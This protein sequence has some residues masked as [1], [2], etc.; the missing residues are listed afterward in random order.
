MPGFLRIL[1]LPFSWIW[2]LALRIRHG[3]YDLGIFASEEAALPC[4]VVGNL[5]L[6]GTGKTPHTLWLAHHYSGKRRIAVLSRGYGRKT[7]GFI[8]VQAGMSAADCGDEALEYLQELDGKAIIAVCEDRPFGIRRLKELHPALELVILDDALQ[9]RALR[10]GY[11]ILLS[12][13]ESPWYKDHLIPAG[14]L[15]DLKIRSGSCDSMILTK[16]GE[17][18]ETP[19]AE[20]R[21]KFQRSVAASTY[22][23]GEPVLA[24]GTMPL[25]FVA[26]A[27]IASPHGFIREIQKRDPGA[28]ARIYRDHHNFTV[29]EIQELARIC[30]EE[31][32]GIATTRKDLMRLEPWLH[33]EL[34]GIAVIYLPVELRFL[35]G[36]NEL[37]HSIDN[38]LSNAY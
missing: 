27:A 14:T 17:S 37:L 23:Y 16:C 31:N 22:I 9:H 28:A 3:L 34:E 29:T 20:A 19:L 33:S 32:R 13:C 35:S 26:V 36:E 10:G 5:S 24:Q 25:R 15:R 4:L 38:F 11:R 12:T 1:L 18:W 30:R 6:G 21:R 2:A 7:R 8:E